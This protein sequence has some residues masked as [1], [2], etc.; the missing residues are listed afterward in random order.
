MFNVTLVSR[1]I[2]DIIE[3][4]SEQLCRLLS[5]LSH[6]A[7]LLSACLTAHFTAQR[8]VAVRFPLSV[9]IEQKVHL[10]HYVIVLICIIFSTIYCL[11][12]VDSNSYDNCHEELELKWFISDAFL[13]F[14]IPFTIITI[15]N[16]LII[17]HFKRSIQNNQQYRFTNSR[18]QSMEM[19]PL[20]F[21]SKSTS[22]NDIQSQTHKL[23]KIN[24]CINL[25]KSKV[26]T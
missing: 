1:C 5:F 17:Y 25:S 22:A 15:L 14:F 16:T 23:L 7:E 9:L 20:N 19:I 21:R 2:H 13:S 18:L 8:F 4:N 26:V 24:D 3:L 10:L 11:A 6:L 12:L